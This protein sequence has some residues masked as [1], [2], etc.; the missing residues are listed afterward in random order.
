MHWSGV[1]RQKGGA[2]AELCPPE[3]IIPSTLECDCSWR[4]GLEKG[5]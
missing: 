5:D 3:V 1:R 4:E 2:F